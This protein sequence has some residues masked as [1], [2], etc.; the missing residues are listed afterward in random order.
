MK[1]KFLFFSLTQLG[2]RCRYIKNQFRDRIL[3]IS[4]I[5]FHLL[6]SPPPSQN[7]RSR[8]GRNPLELSSVVLM[9]SS[10]ISSIGIF[11][12]DKM[13]VLCSTCGGGMENYSEWNKQGV[14]QLK[15]NPKWDFPLQLIDSPTSVSPFV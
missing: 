8:H 14:L 2:W 12:L 3:L 6:N 1:R 15:P 5:Q 7:V 11:T 10:W 9:W 13:Q 4:K